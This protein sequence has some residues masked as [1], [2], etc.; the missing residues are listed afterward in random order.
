MYHDT[1]QNGIKITTV[2]IKTDCTQG[3]SKS[4]L[5][6]KDSKNKREYVS[7]NYTYCSIF[8]VGD[9]ISVYKNQEKDWYE[10]DPLMLIQ[11][12]KK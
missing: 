4:K 6:F 10:I 12:M 5:Y 8:N 7:L 11:R 1:I 2:I 3:R 9:T